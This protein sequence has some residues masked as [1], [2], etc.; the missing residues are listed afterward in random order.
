MYKLCLPSLEVSNF[1]C[2][3]RYVHKFVFQMASETTKSC[4]RWLP[5]WV[6]KPAKKFRRFFLCA[7]KAEKREEFEVT[8][9]PLEISPPI[10]RDCKTAAFQQ[11]GPLTDQLECVFRRYFR[12]RVDQFAMADVHSERSAFGRHR[13]IRHAK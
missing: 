5:K 2:G 10:S 4:R 9:E 8:I 12:R 6:K 7:G 3:L 11:L 13:Q 1:R